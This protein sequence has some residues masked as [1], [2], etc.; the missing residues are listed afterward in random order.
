MAFPYF[1]VQHLSWGWLHSIL[2]T[3]LSGQCTKTSNLFGVLAA[4]VVDGG[5]LLR[6]G[7]LRGWRT[8]KKLV[9]SQLLNNS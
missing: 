9:V 7:S 1:V 6:T 4:A 8:G 3:F 2:E 5:G